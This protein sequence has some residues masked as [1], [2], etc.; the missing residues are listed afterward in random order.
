MIHLKLIKNQFLQFIKSVVNLHRE[1]IDI[2]NKQVGKVGV[3][4]S[5]A[6]PLEYLE[7]II[8]D[9]DLIL[10]MAVNPGFKGQGLIPQTLRKISNLKNKISK[11]NLNTLISVDGNVNENNITGH[12]ICGSRYISIRF[13]WII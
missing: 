2:K 8:E 12:G 1:I 9:I 7:Y 6:T 13:K 4:L 5:P 11:M 3:A 10:L